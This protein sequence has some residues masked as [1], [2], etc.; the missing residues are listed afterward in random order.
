MRTTSDDVGRV[1]DRDLVNRP[2]VA[3]SFAGP[4]AA[5]HKGNQGRSEAWDC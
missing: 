2:M 4:L 5:P 1:E 3:P